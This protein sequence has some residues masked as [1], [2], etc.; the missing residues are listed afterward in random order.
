[1]KTIRYGLEIF[2]FITLATATLLFVMVRNYSY[3]N[4][5]IFS[6][7]I[8]PE[9]TPIP[10]LTPAEPHISIMDSPDGS[11]TLTLENNDNKGISEY[12]LF[13]SSEQ[14]T[15][16]KIFGKSEEA[17]QS[18]EIPF[19]TWSPDNI[20]VFLK[21]KTSAQDNYLV[22]KSSG[23]LFADGMQYVSIQELFKKKVP[24]YIIM[25]VTGWAD[26]TLLIINAES[27]DDNGKVSF[28]F[29]IV[30]QSFMRL[31]TYFK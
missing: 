4:K 1:M 12:S 27:Q 3:K 18:L 14:E 16:Q 19:N 15:K 20:Y 6:V 21:E 9:V 2:F 28:W 22:F 24:N 26:N 29:D 5:A 31:G 10:V 17:S 11:K 7:S 8:P 25:D 23:A 30:N 13:V